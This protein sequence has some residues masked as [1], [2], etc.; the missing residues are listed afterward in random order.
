MVLGVPSA[1]RPNFPRRG[2][3]IGPVRLK[4][5]FSMAVSMM[6]ALIDGSSAAS[7]DAPLA[8]RSR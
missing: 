3:N 2:L 1:L 7:G 4:D 8:R 6:P 5:I